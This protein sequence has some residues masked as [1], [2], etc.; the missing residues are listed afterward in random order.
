MTD[1]EDA[2]ELGSSTARGGFRNEDD[3]IPID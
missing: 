3:V 1:K 2:E